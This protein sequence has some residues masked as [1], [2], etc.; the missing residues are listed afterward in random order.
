MAQPQPYLSP[1]S[2]PERF[3]H[4]HS[5]GGPGSHNFGSHRERPNSVCS[6]NSSIDEVDE[7]EEHS[8][9]GSSAQNNTSYV[10]PFTHPPPTWKSYSD[11][12]LDQNNHYSFY[13]TVG[14]RTSTGASFNGSS[15]A[16]VVPVTGQSGLSKSWVYSPIAAVSENGE[17]GSKPLPTPPQT[18]ESQETST[19]PFLDSI[20]PQDIPAAEGL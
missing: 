7:G 18:D 17:S 8:G 4:F 9:S 1:L 3:Q 15:S 12:Q 2:L 19:K 10:A 11:D 5:S 20:A 6:N 13:N 16:R 14:N